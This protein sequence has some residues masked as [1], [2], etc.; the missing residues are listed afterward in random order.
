MHSLVA[1]KL[2]NDY[3]NEKHLDMQYN[4]AETEFPAQIVCLRSN[5]TVIIEVMSRNHAS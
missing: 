3:I 5:V 4:T 2:W 1:L